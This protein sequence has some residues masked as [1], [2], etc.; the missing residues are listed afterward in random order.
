MFWCKWL[1]RKNRWRKW[2]NEWTEW[3]HEWLMDKRLVERR[4]NEWNI[5][6]INK[7][8]DERNEKMNKLNK[9]MI[10]WMHEWMN[11]WMDGWMDGWVGGWMEHMELWMSELFLFRAISSLSDHTSYLSYYFSEQH[12]IWAASSQTL[13]RSCLPASF[14]VAS[15]TQFLSSQRLRCVQQPLATS[16]CNPA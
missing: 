11:E 6:G 7:R 9:W 10:E 2:K 13:L 1:G 12:L 15:A 4:M 14:S 3:T 8:R 5:E 16:S